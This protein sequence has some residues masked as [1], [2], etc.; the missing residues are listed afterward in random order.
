MASRKP[1]DRYRAVL[2]AKRFGTTPIDVR[3]R[4]LYDLLTGTGTNAN[5]AY[6]HEL[7]AREFRR[8]ILQAWIVAGATDEQ[9]QTCLRVPI[10]V[11][12]AYRHL[13]FDVTAFRDDLELFDWVNSY[14]G[15]PSG[16][17]LLQQATMSGITG[18]MWMYNRG[19]VKIDPKAVLR[20]AMTDAH[21]RSHAGRFNGI[22]TREAEAAH[23]HMKTAMSAASQLAKGDTGNLLADLL[24]RLQHRD[25]TTPVTEELA[26]NL[27]H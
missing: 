23:K 1:D 10:D 17:V 5:V 24:I 9:V 18:L 14:A 16:K 19:D 21:F 13:F 15:T 4:A 7:Y 27:L 12:S 8:E 2:D 11:V 6:A 3:E 26:E 25:M 22:A 20:Q